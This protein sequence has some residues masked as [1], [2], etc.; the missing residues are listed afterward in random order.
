LA[1]GG[2]PMEL[3]GGVADVRP[4]A[5][6]IVTGAPDPARALQAIRSNAYSYFHKPI[7][8]NAV[9][10]MVQQA[11]EARS[12]RDDIRV[13]SSHPDWISLEVRAKLEAVERTTHMMREIEADLPRP[14]CEDVTAAFRELLLNAVEH[15]AHSDPHKRVRVTLVRIAGF[16]VATLADP[17]EGFSLDQ[18]PHAAV[19]NPA[20][21]PTRHAGVREEQGQRPGG[22]GILMTRNLVDGLVYNE[23]GNEVTFLKK[24]S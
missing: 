1:G 21:D 15:G 13:V 12:W 23:R 3:V 10:D 9:A 22:F 24:L 2:D 5:R 11:V 8:P 7:A 20:G 6:V 19:S 14:I 16:L 18:L 17:G 4:H